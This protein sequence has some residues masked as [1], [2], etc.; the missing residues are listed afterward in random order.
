MKYFLAFTAKRPLPEWRS[1]YF[2]DNELSDTIDKTQNKKP[3]ILFV[4]TFNR[5]YEPENIR[6]AIKVLKAAGFS[7]LFQS[8]KILKIHY[9]VEEHI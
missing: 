5:Y 4:D 7:L 6:S 2:K 8:Q 1:D 9:A 3:V